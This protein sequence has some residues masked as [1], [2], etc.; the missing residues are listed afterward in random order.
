MYFRF[1]PNIKTMV[2]INGM[3]VMGL[4]A[5][6]PCCAMTSVGSTVSVRLPEGQGV[7]WEYMVIVRVARNIRNPAEEEQVNRNAVK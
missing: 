3:R 1:L 7:V 2:L 6:S 4:K 5:A